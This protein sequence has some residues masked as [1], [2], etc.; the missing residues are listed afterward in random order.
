MIS[1]RQN[2]AAS[3]TAKGESDAQIIKN[4][5]DKEV[6]ITLAEAEK[7]AETIIAEGEA[8]YMRILSEAYND[9]AKAEFYNYLR[10]LDALKASLK[11]NGNILMLDKDSELVKILY[12]TDEA[13]DVKY[14]DLLKE[15]ATEATTEQSTEATTEAATEATTETATEATTEEE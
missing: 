11:K 4:E 10:A 2:I 13:L 8:E 5:T 6:T 15:Q 9:P 7:D 1:E 3:Y 12:G 14:E